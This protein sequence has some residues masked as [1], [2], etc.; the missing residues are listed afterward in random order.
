MTRL[1]SML[2]SVQFVFL[3]ALFGRGQP[4]SA[5]N[6]SL[7]QS[8]IEHRWRDDNKAHE[9]TYAELWHNKNF[10][11]LG[12]L[13]VDESAKLE[14]ISLG[15]K[16]YL[17][18][19][20]DNGI[21]L[22]GKDVTLEEESYSS[23]INT[24]RAKGMRE[25]ISEIVSR[26]IDLGLNLDLI[27]QYFR[28]EVIGV[29]SVNGRDAFEFLC[30]PHADIKPKSKADR[31]ATQFCIRVWVDAKDLTFSRIEAELLTNQSHM[32]P[33][34]TAS[35]T[36]EALDGIWLPQLMIIRGKAKEGRLIVPFE[37]E[38]RYNDYRKY[39]SNSRIVGEPIPVH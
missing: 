13:I 9:F 24:G 39:H 8:A 32:R 35:I 4:S 22:Q 38:Y 23:S 15:G 16:A 11:K 20:E 12:K 2:A 37:T 30:T 5:S 21:P 34:T 19:I 29:N 14:S 6:S 25:R 18:M 10:D 3:L 27:P 28:T 36:W 17:R 7:I 33:G 26:S 31:A 1:I